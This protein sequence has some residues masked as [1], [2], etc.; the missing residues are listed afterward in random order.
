MLLTRKEKRRNRTH[1]NLLVYFITFQKPLVLFFVHFTFEKVNINLF[2]FSEIQF[3][4]SKATSISITLII[5]QVLKFRY[6]NKEQQKKR[7]EICVYLIQINIC[8]IKK[9]DE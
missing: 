6:N 8:Q 4:V 3:M 2:I 1:L 5:K 9:N 7:I